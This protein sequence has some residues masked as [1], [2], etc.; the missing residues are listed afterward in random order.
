MS[1]RR[2]EGNKAI[3]PTYTIKELPSADRPRERL[4]ALGPDHLSNTEL[5][6][7][8]LR[9]GTT[10][11]SALAL[12]NRLIA[13]AGGI[14]KLAAMRPA[15]LAT[16]KGLGAAKAAQVLAAL[17][18]GRRV[19]MMPWRDRPTISRP[20]DVAPLL[21]ELMGQLEQEQFHVLLLDARNRIIADTTLYRG[22]AT[23]SVVRPAEVFREALRHNAVSIIVAH[24]H[25]SGDP[26]PSAD[27]VA[28]TRALVQAGKLMGIEVLDHLVIGL[29]S[30]KSLR[31]L[32]LGF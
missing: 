8:L 7:I 14:D 25:P 21:L 10:G 20:E 6:A 15:E 26:T 29:A 31:A 3:P 11:E 12:A 30:W 17:E 4:M 32:G 16:I 24:N 1:N 27:D 28:V 13:T 23:S 9:T 2:L 5:L 18:L 22:N 19:R